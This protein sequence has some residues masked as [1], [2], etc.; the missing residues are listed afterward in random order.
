MSH[1]YPETSLLGTSITDSVF[2]SLDSSCYCGGSVYRSIG[3]QR[4][5]GKYGIPGIGRPKQLFRDPCIGSEKK[6]WTM[7]WINT[8]WAPM[9]MESCPVGNSY[10]HVIDL[11]RTNDVWE[12]MCMDW[13]KTT[14]ALS[15]MPPVSKPLFKVLF[16]AWMDREGVRERNKKNVSG[17]CD[18][19]P[20]SIFGNLELIMLIIVLFILYSM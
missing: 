2:Y 16:Q 20:R 17:K 5:C 18:S 15:G 7:V 3:K 4:R 10:K 9:N 19:K 11:T 12:E 6:E 8:V 14:Q 13:E 1:D